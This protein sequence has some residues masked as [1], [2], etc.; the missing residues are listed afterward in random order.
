M[1]DILVT[2]SLLISDWL[3]SI[4]GWVLWISISEIKL[5]YPWSEV[6]QLVSQIIV[7]IIFSKYLRAATSMQPANAISHSLIL[8]RKI[9][10]KYTHISEDKRC[11]LPLTAEKAMAP[12]SRTLT[13]KIPWTAEPGRLQSM[14]LLRVRHDWATSLSLFTFMHWRRKWQPTAVFLPGES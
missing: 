12:H 2:R 8:G 11:S 7:L 9:K 6:T 13:W 4:V 5:Q 14:R 10:N 3:T 1:S